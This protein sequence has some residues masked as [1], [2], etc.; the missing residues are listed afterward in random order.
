VLELH[1]PLGLSR[2][3]LSGAAHDVLVLPR[4]EHVRHVVAEGGGRSAS[5]TLR[6]GA[7]ENEL[8]GLRPYRP[9]AAASRI[10][11]PAVARL[12]ELVERRLVTEADATPLVVLD[13][14]APMDDEALDMAVRAA[15]S[16]SRTLARSG[17][18][19]VLLP[20]DTRPTTLDL[21]M[22]EWPRLWARLAV[23]GPAAAPPRLAGAASAT[24]LFWVTARA[25]GPRAHLV[26]SSGEAFVVGPAVAATGRPAFVVAG[27]EARRLRQRQE[28][29]A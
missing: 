19:R 1:D 29:V 16:L 24:T 26:P 9:G 28:L 10:H 5:R 23:V 21:P 6:G 25:A 18:C 27:C 14:S 2:R 11:W 8:D 4:T 17:G 22:R 3:H 20:G 15:G 13:A 12:G 7:E